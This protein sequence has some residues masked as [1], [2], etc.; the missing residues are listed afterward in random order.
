MKRLSNFQ[1]SIFNFVFIALLMTPVFIKAAEPPALS[2]SPPFQEVTINPGQAETQLKVSVDNNSDQSQTFRVSA[3]DFGTLDETG[4]VAFLGSQA[5]AL[6][7]K[8][9]LVNWLRLD[10]SSVTVAPKKSATV[11]AT[12]LNQDTLSPGGH[13]A[14][15]LF[16]LESKPAPGNE[17]RVAVNQAFSSLIFAKKIGGAKFGLELDK[18]NQP[19][20]WRLPERI[21]LRFYNS[22]NVHNVPRGLV[23][24]IGPR[25]NTVAQGTIN[26]ESAMILPETHRRYVVKMQQSG[27]ALLPGKYQLKV[28][29][30]YD[31]KAEFTELTQDFYFTNLPG[32][33]LAALGLIGLG[34]V[35]G[36]LLTR[37]RLRQG[38]KKA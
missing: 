26:T 7:R 30:R 4:G 3:L 33:G 1:F 22:G 15:I 19:S 29:Y 24:I 13:Y 20:K 6:Q 21:G 18:P 11:T 10:R 8:Y 35:L 2:V 12:I 27:S 14:S 34:L 23:S 5:T 32:L 17:P 37:F 31:G 28:Q 38:T 16:T 25:G 36:L 9:G